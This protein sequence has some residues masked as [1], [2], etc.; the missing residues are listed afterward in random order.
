M[1]NCC[2]SLVIAIKPGTKEHVH[3]A[4]HVISHSKEE[5]AATRAVYSSNIIYEF[6]RLLKLSCASD[7]LVS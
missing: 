1:H 2:D 3:T 4:S 6:S 7:A 5:T